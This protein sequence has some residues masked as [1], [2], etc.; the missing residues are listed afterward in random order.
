[1]NKRIENQISCDRFADNIAAF[2]DG[3]L[4]ETDFLLMETHRATCYSCAKALVEEE[5]F[6]VVM[7]EIPTVEV[8]SDFRDRVLRS[9]RIKHDTV[10][11]AISAD[12]MKKMILILGAVAIVLLMLPSARVALFSTASQLSGAI[13]RIPQQ[14][15]SGIEV[16]FRLPTI[17]MIH[18]WLQVWQGRV[19]ENLGNLGSA[20]APW[21][22]FFRIAIAL[23]VIAIV[24]IT[25]LSW[26]RQY[27][28]TGT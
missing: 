9:W 16:S 24:I 3:T 11:R 8:P 19:Y 2:L 27:R 20:I 26:I 22:S 17:P 14:Y 21:I 12:L 10:D 1:M 23:S 18:A 13:D 5:K 6:R 7:A 4:S 28:G 25:R 15:R